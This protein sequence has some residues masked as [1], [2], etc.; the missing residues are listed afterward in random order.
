MF[1]DFRNSTA[2]MQTI[3]FAR[4]ESELPEN[5]LIVF[6][7][8]WGSLRGHLGNAMHLKRAADCGRQ[9]AA[10]TVERNDD[11]VRLELG[12]IDHLLWTTHRSERHVNAVEYLVPMSH[13]L[14]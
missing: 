10:G 1:P 7:N 13:W 2:F 4:A 3:D 9:L 8:F 14:G 6:S 5:L 11:V 12:I